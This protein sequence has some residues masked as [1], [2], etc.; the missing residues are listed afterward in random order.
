MQLPNACLKKTGFNLEEKKKTTQR[1]VF[2][3]FL[4]PLIHK[5]KYGQSKRCLEQI[6]LSAKLCR[7]CGVVIVDLY[8]VV[9]ISFVTHIQTQSAKVK[10][11][12]RLVSE[13]KLVIELCP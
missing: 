8:D 13:S 3:Q 1:M 7:G 12:A 2:F 9:E 10:T 4:L 5:L 6:T 11:D